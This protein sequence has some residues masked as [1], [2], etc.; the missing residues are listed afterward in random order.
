[1][2]WEELEA[3]NITITFYAN[4]TV[5]NIGS[6]EVNVIKEKSNL[7]L[8]ISLSVT[9]PS[10]IAIGT[11]ITIIVLRSRRVVPTR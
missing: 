8:I 2:L 1:V 3:G 5:G 6:A 7:A 4:D 10:A 11:V 9:I